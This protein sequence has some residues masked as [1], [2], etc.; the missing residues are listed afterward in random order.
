MA[1]GLRVLVVGS[2][3][4]EHALALALSRDDGIAEVHVAPGNP[5]TAQV[6]TNHPVDVLDGTAVA[7]IAVRLGVDLV[8]VGP[9]APLVAGVADMVRAA[10][11]AVFGP[12]R[13]AAQIEGSKAFAK[14]VMAAAG[15]PTGPSF[16][17]RNPDE[18]RAALAQ[19]GPPYVVKDDGLAAG[20]G[21]VVT[22]DRDT[23]LEHAA[24]CDRVVVEEFLDG[25]EVSLFAITDGTVVLPMQPAQDFKR[26][27]DGD[28]GP[29][30]GGM[31]A[32]TPL[33]WAPPDLVE[34]VTRTVLQPTVDEMARRGSPFAG[35]LYAGLAL[36]S[37]GVRVIEFNA[38]FGDPE[39]QVLLARLRTPLGGLLL[40]A[41]SGSLA[42]HPP[43]QW[44]PG[45]AV[46]VVLSSEGYPGTP[47]TGGP[48][49]G[50]DAATGERAHVVHAGTALDPEGNLV[51]AGGRV[52]A[53]VGT[54]D[55]LAGAREVAYRS[56]GRISLA[57]AHYR[58]DIAEAAARAGADA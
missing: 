39:T 1:H 6:A 46:A 25:P 56:I 43:L 23:A 58:H 54:G 34:E 29:N 50:L 57:G 16:T 19:F 22:S 15:V 55:D 20:K 40:A 26:V 41:A 8:V 53:V 31:G 24:R 2:G 35:L 27:G 3:G 11:I 18:A 13:A 45:A 30:T 37:Q 5:G 36:T 4:R 10:G 7:E 33:P 38:R 48:I 42:H 32:Y 28:T 21:V 14:E 44:D 49:T 12:S 52:L 51:S 47:V 17:C 9:E